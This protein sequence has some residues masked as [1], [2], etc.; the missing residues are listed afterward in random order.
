MYRQILGDVTFP[1]DNGLTIFK[2]IETGNLTIYSDGTILNGCGAHAF[3][4]HTDT[5]RDDTAVTG[6]ALTRGDPDTLS[7]LLTEHFGYLAGVL[8]TWVVVQKYQVSQGHIQGAVDN[9]TVVQRMNDGIDPEVGHK[10]LLATDY[11]VWKETEHILRVLPLTASLRHIKG[12]QDDL[13]KKG[14][15]GPLGRDAFWNVCMDALAKTP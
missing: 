2:A 14:I 1:E 8:V 9:M 10:Q 4:L 11:D 12:H 15:S 3:T 13:H 6:S 5:D 7:S